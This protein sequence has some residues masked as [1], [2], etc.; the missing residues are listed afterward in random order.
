MAAALAL[1]LLLSLGRWQV[2]RAAEKQE[3]QALLDAR[4]AAAPLDLTG[5]VDSAE[6]LLFHRVRAKG[7]WLAD[8]QVY[9]DNQI[10]DGR[11]GFGVVTPLR[12]AGGEAVLVNRGWVARDASYPK[13]PPVPAPPG[14]VQVSGLATLPPARYLEFSHDTV[15]GNVWQNLSIDRFRAHTGLAVLPV[16]ILD[17]HPAPGLKPMRERPDAGVAKHQEY[18]LTWFALAATVLALWVALNLRRER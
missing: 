3:R 12:L 4:I 6:P 17:D 15:T 7:E 14:P 2:N 16:V 13:A 1:A 9:V 8:R 18:A 5:A 11:A 10:R